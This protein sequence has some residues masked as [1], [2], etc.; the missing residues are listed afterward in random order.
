MFET[1]LLCLALNIY[2]EARDQPV[3]GMQAVAEV[4][5]NRVDDKRFPDTVCEVVTQ[6]PTYKWKRDFPVRH[7]CQFSWYCDGKSDRPK[8]NT[9]WAVS[10]A[11]ANSVLETGSTGIAGY[12]THYHNIR[13][14]PNWSSTKIL[15]GK[16][17]DHVF[18]RW[19]VR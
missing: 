4:V 8:D 16:I 3:L 1:A 5:L 19:A 7:R 9:A 2:H 12:A 6:G 15:I 18:Y 11:V 13:V 17:G 14:R 10:K